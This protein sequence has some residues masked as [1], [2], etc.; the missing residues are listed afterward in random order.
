MLLLPRDLLEKLEFDKLSEI[1]AGYCY[2]DLGIKRIKNLEF[3]TDKPNVVRRLDETHEYLQ[4]QENSEPIPM[5]SYQSLN[6]DLK[7][8]AIEDFV[9]S[10]ESLGRINQTLIAS[11]NINNYFKGERQEL[12]PQLF[13][14]TRPI[15]FEPGLIEAIERVIDENNQIRLSGGR[16]NLKNKNQGGKGSN[17][18]TP[19]DRK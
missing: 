5:R 10:E 14:L 6:E 13:N 17:Q 18:V 11:H 3:F 2:G 8:L 1:T 12:Y 15:E 16:S 19:R 9:L 7:M 4:A